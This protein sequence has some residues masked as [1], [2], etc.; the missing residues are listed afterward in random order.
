MDKVQNAGNTDQPKSHVDIWKVAEAKAV[1][2]R[3]GDVTSC[4]N[5]V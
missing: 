1:Y 4:Y 5:V 3:E 2:P